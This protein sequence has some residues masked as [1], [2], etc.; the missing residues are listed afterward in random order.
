MNS[1]Q[2]LTVINAW[3]KWN[4]KVY[5]LLFTGFKDNDDNIPMHIPSDETMDTE[6]QSYKERTSVSDFLRNNVKSASGGKLFEYVYPPI[7]GTREV[8]VTWENYSDATAYIMV[9]QG[10][11]AREMNARA[12][13]KVFDQPAEA[14]KASKNSKWQPY[15]RVAEIVETVVEKMPNNNKN[16]TK[17]Y[18]G[19]DNK[20]YPGPTPAEHGSNNTNQGNLD[21]TR[22]YVGVASNSSGGGN[23]PHKNDR[24]ANLLG[25]TAPNGKPYGGGTQPGDTTHTGRAGGV[26]GNAQRQDLT[27]NSQLSIQTTNNDIEVLKKQVRTLQ[28]T[29]ANIK[30]DFKKDLNQLSVTVMADMN[31]KLDTNNVKLRNELTETLVSE[32]KTVT[33][34]NFNLVELI[35]SLKMDIKGSQD[36]TQKQIDSINQQA[37]KKMEKTTNKLLSEIHKTQASNIKY[38]AKISES[39][40]FNDFQADS[41]SD[42]N[43][44]FS[45][46]YEQET[47]NINPTTSTTGNKHDNH[48]EGATPIL[49]QRMEE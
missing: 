32:I 4:S 45:F 19:N 39:S 48:Q 10:E 42:S 3:R 34:S 14:T 38:R 35:Q 44:D 7:Q 24:S 49:A 12:I 46:D 2:K 33:D 28:T 16:Y 13:R 20:H 8:M 30:G 17:R 36:K 23:S 1:G 40:I 22:S 26:P 41:E 25:D 11:L 6:T 31:E 9:G 37:D 29:V 15:A 21:N 27:P 5:S 47:E 18:R 43:V